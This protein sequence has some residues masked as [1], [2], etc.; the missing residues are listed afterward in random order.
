MCK[1]FSAFPAK[2]LHMIRDPLPEQTALFAPEDFQT[3][4]GNGLD[5]DNRWVRWAQQI[6]WTELARIYHRSLKAGGRPAKPARLVIG[7]LIIKHRLGLSDV[8]TIEQVKE[9]PYLQY[10]CG[11]ER[12]QRE[13]AFAPT[14][15]V[16]LRKRLSPA[17]FAEFEQA[18]IDRMKA[19]D[20]A[21]RTN[22]P[23]GDDLP[24]AGA[25]GQ[26]SGKGSG[27]D[28]S[29]PSGQD[30]PAEGESTKAR[31]DTALV[32]DAS[33]AEQRIRYPS[34]VSLL[35]EA[36][37]KAEA[38]IDRLWGRLTEVAVAEGRK[39]R[40][41]R[42]R[43]RQ[44][45]LRYSK[46]RS[47]G[48]RRA[49]RA[50]RAQLQYLRRDLAHIDALLDHWE[51]VMPGGA[52]PL[53][54]GEQRQLWIIRALY[55]QQETM[56]RQGSRR[57]DDRLVSLSQPQ[58]RP[59]VRGRLGH[60][61]EF[62]SKFSVS[63]NPGGIACVDALRWAAFS[64]AG[65]LIR[66][67]QAYYNRYG[68]YPDKV[69][70]DAIYGTR[71]NRRWLKD[72]GIAYAG[73]PLGRPPQL[74]PEQGKAL[75]HQRRADTS[76]AWIR[77]IFLVM[78]LLALLKRLFW[79]WEQAGGGEPAPQRLQIVVTGQTDRALR[80]SATAQEISVSKIFIAIAAF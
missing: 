46:S 78:N 62:G 66:Q 1:D 3:P 43:A 74:S 24:P 23:S 69:L 17:R 8:E 26:N 77:A 65:D 50:R 35:N 15:F 30:G 10:F 55:R 6:P 42:K 41:Y 36:R 71:A 47:R 58:V 2:G 52:F 32:I 18:V 60:P 63:L 40:T 70:A 9:N 67:C 12:F 37:E 22:T 64:E 31:S 75:A 44:D 73:K 72:N 29:P 21:P 11:F 61:V 45:Y 7:A 25:P 51:T 80:H 59:I 16:E 53:G 14:L 19:L 76:E 28:S 20:K 38:L 34:D 68:H 49:R 48:G 39:P 57:I 5:P 13:A 4:F 56:H 79:L 33:V 54:R 27:G